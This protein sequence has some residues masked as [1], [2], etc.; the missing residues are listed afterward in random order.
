MDGLSKNLKL[1]ARRQRG[2]YFVDLEDGEFQ[3]PMQNARKKLEIQ[4]EA[5]MPCKK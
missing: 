4:M 5:A 3:E 1:D 2:I